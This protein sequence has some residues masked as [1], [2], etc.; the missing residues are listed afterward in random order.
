[1]VQRIES[2]LAQ[3]KASDFNP[4]YFS[5][6]IQCALLLILLI[7]EGPSGSVQGLLLV[8]YLEIIY[9]GAQGTIYDVE[10]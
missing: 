5:K 4:S 2:G 7:F 6:S 10:D 1:M 8:L 9:G 3:Y